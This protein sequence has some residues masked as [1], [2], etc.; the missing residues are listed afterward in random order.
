[1]VDLGY[2]KHLRVDHGVNEFARGRS[3]VNGIESFWS[4]DKRRLAKFNGIPKHT[5]YLHLKE[6]EFRFNYRKENLYE[7]TLDIL[8]KNPA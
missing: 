3:H 4:Y 2:E 5:F 1:M 8:R 7:K 6:S